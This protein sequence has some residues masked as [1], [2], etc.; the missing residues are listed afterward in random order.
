MVL[1]VFSTSRS[2]LHD[3]E[4]VYPQVQYTDTFADCDSVLES[5]GE[6]IV[7]KALSESIVVFRG[8]LQKRWVWTPTVT[9][10]RVL[11]DKASAR[12][13]AYEARCVLV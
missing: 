12:F 1:P 10:C 8:Q 4:T 6:L 7:G 5:F 2:D 11:P 13:C 9:E 3:T